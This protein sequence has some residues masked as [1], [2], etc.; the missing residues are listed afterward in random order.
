MSGT[1]YS[2][3][4]AKAR[5]ASPATILEAIDKVLLHNKQACYEEMEPYMR[6][7]ANTGST[8]YDHS[9]CARILM[10]H[11]AALDRTLSTIVNEKKMSE[12][13]IWAKLLIVLRKNN[14]VF[15]HGKLTGLALPATEEPKSEEG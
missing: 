10:A 3:A 2:Y 9:H 6:G 14:F 15:E 11:D 13:E 5:T 12:K 4:E 7:I 1:L 8:Q